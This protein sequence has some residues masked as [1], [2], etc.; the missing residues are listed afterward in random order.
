MIRS[1]LQFLK[2]SLACSREC[3]GERQK[4]KQGNNQKSGI[5]VQGRGKGDLS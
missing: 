5:I 2:E 4:W 1:D 3:T